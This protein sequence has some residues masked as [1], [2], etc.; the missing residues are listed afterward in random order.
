MK[1]M[2]EMERNIFLHSQS[3]AYRTTAVLLCIWTLYNC[4]QTLGSGADY[5]PLP[6]LILWFSVCVQSFSQIAIRQKMVEGDEEYTQPN[7]LLRIILATVVLTV[8]I[9][10]LGTLILVKG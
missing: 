2:D 5:Q 9:L 7:Q 10:S 6:G 4:W 1:K 8:I 3:L